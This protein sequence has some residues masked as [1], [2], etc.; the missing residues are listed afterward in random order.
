M[1]A[2]FNPSF[3]SASVPDSSDE[4]PAE[5]DLVRAFEAGREEI[6]EAGKPLLTAGRSLTHAVLL[7]RGL[8]RTS[9]PVSRYRSMLRGLVAGPALLDSSVLSARPES[10]YSATALVESVVVH[11]DE[12]AL[13]AWLEGHPRAALR[14]LQ[15]TSASERLLV[16][17]LRH[18]EL[19]LPERVDDLIG[20]YLD[21][22][23]FIGHGADAE[24]P[25]TNEII[26][27]DLGV[28]ARSISGA[29][30]HLQREHV[31]RRTQRG[32]KVVRADGLTAATSFFLPPG[33]ID[34]QPRG[35][36]IRRNGWLV[37]DGGDATRHEIGSELRIG[38]SSECRVCLPELEARHC[39]VFRAA[40][41][42]RFWIEAL[43][44]SGSLWL[45][46]RVV[47]RAVLSDGDLIVIGNHRL[48]F[49]E[50]SQ[51]PTP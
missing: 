18:Q 6:V 30:R 13:C 42:E 29:L 1:H 20:S 43:R 9:W 46:G 25:L 21:A 22:Y 16:Q 26:A 11:L 7:K 40:T 4:S 36:A 12:S 37:I 10:A 14:L 33:W 2:A 8:V 24:L 38:S 3:Q 19:V 41:S 35:G 44:T 48:R 49:R 45:N 39:R 5:R 31:V 32:M 47:T 17:R 50:V 51:D 34:A 23:R 15:Q 27:A 28:V